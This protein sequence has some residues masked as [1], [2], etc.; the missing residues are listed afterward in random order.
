MEDVKETKEAIVALVK[1]GKFLAV[2]AKD[3]LDIK[4]I[5]ALTAKLVSDEQF[6]LALVEGIEGSAKIPVEMKEISF[7]KGIEIALAVIAELKK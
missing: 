1:L 5:G 6:R 4:D 3:G 2:Q 7:E